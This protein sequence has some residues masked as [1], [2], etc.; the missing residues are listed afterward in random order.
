[1]KVYFDTIGCRLNQSEIEAYASQLRTAG[2]EIIEDAAEADLVIVNTCMVTAAAE[3]DSR[4]KI[5]QA[6]RAGGKAVIATGCWA[7][8]N[9]ARA[10]ELA[11]VERVIPNSEKD[12]LISEILAIPSGTEPGMEKRIPLPGIHKRTRAFVKVQDGC[13]NHCTYCVTRL[14]RG[15]AHSQSVE[16]VL[17]PIRAAIEG[18]SKEIILT[19]V[20]LGWWGRDFDPQMR[21]ADLIKIILGELGDRRLRLSSV[22]PW[23]IEDSF[24]DLFSDP[25]MCRQL[26]F[27]LQ[28]GS[29]KILRQ[30]ARKTTPET[31]SMIVNQA[32]Q[33]IPGVAITTDVIVGFPG[34]TDEDFAESMEF[35]ERMNF[36]GGHV[37]SY[38]PRPGTPAAKYPDQVPP[39]VKHHRSKILHQVF[40]EAA[41][42]Y[43]EQFIGKTLTVL[44]ES[45]KQ[46]E[47]GKWL[48]GGWTDNYIRVTA[49]SDQQLWNQISHV[50]LENLAD[51]QGCL[52]RIVS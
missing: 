37:F 45:S 10:L 25:R 6:Y 36:A 30:M 44:W 41:Q 22:E 19:G 16:Q 1:M 50:Q 29:A 39:D 23:D 34:E 31:Y 47:S 51:G 42:R 32:R 18:G 52:G 7:T 2:H 5:R 46:G 13:N 24:Y 3:S 48:L 15:A 26:H 43:Q 12:Q 8:L 4:Q 20:H 33:S 38:S 40:E 28:S 27:P 14:A 49:P 21:I 11:G 17:L 9:P 35:V